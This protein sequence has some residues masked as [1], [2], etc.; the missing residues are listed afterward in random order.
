MISSSQR[1]LRDKTQ[2]S[3]AVIH[4]PAGFEPTISAGERPQT[5]ALDRAT[6]GTGTLLLGDY[7]KDELNGTCSMHDGYDGCVKGF[8]QQSPSSTAFVWPNSGWENITEVDL[9]ECIV[10][11]WNEFCPFLLGC[12]ERCCRHSLSKKARR[13]L[14][15]WLTISCSRKVLRRGLIYVV[16]D[17]ALAKWTVFYL[18][19]CWF[20][21]FGSVSCSAAFWT[22]FLQFDSRQEI[23]ERSFLHGRSISPFPSSSFHLTLSSPVRRN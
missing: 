10:R 5:Y 23:H 21:L 8:N 7:M 4:T 12:S 19:L 13:F 22:T 9:K 14:T 6:S 15:Y 16:Y 3:T 11:V 2:H 20:E 18:L 17:L 1:P